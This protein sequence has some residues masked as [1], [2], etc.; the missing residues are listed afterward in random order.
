ME[1]TFVVDRIEDGEIAVLEDEEGRTFP[2]PRA[3]LP[4]GIREGDVVRLALEND[5]RDERV[6]R[7]TLDPEVRERRREEI[8]AL[9]QRLTR[10]PGGDISL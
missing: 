8:L 10:G 9:R 3:W 4:G 2:V 6:L 1:A 5:D 7:F